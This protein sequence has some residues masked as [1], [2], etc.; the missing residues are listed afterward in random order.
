[1]PVNVVNLPTPPECEGSQWSVGDYAQLVNLTGLAM[2]GRARHAINILNGSQQGPLVA[3]PV[4]KARL[5]R[6]LVLAVGVD[7]WHRDGLLFETI[8]WLV[9]RIEGGPDEIISDPHRK[10]TQQ[11]ADNVKVRVDPIARALV[12]A[13]VYEYKCTDR[14]R[15]VFRDDVLPAFAKYLS[16]ARDDELTQTTIALLDQYGLT[17]AEQTL[18]YEALVLNRPLAFQAALTVSPDVF[19]VANCSALFKDYDGL[20]IPLA[21]R[22]GDTFPLADIRAWFEMFA[23]DVWAWI[24]ANV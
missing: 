1:M 19:P 8:C 14:A 5:R 3:N 4:L 11:G 23:A 24:D 17:D 15:D 21:S 13:T 7:P 22:R 16:G 12:T 2:L 20:P 10:A 9:A 6:E 18:A